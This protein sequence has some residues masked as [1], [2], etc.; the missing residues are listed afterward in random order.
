M[1]RQD[2]DQGKGD[3]GHHHQRCEV[4]A[5]PADHQHVDQHHHQ[6]EGQPQVAEDLKGDVPLAVPLDRRLQ[7]AERLLEVEQFDLVAT[8]AE[9]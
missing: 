1:G 8:T 3:R 6:A 4:V 9:F 5:K 2:T 7:A